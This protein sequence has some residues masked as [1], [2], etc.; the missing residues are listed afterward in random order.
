MKL[1]VQTILFCVHHMG[2]LQ[3]CVAHEKWHCL[4]LRARAQI[5]VLE[6]AR[7]YLICYWWIMTYM[8]E[9]QWLPNTV[10]RRSQLGVWKIMAR[11]QID[12]ATCGLLQIRAKLWKFLLTSVDLGVGYLGSTDSV[13]TIFELLSCSVEHVRWNSR[14]RIPDMG[15]QVKSSSPLISVRNTLLLT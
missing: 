11:K 1:A 7:I 8:L 13:Q 12:L 6:N 3:T 10:C 4:C 15:L 14:D 5:C 9:W 2:S